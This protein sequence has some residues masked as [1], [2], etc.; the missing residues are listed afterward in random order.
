VKSIDLR[1]LSLS[2]ASLKYLQY[3]TTEIGCW[4]FGRLSRITE[5]ARADRYPERRNKSL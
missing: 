4:Y 1:D 5:P 3:K 2:G